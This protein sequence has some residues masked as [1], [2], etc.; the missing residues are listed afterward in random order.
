MSYSKKQIN[1]QFIHCLHINSIT[2]ASEFN[3]LFAL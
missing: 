3:L 1:C 2:N